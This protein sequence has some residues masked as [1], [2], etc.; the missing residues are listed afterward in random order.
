[1]AGGFQLNEVTA[2][3]TTRGSG[4]RS[5]IRPIV[6]E[7]V[8]AGVVPRRG[9][10]AL[11]SKVGDFRA[12]GNGRIIPRNKCLSRGIILGNYFLSQSSMPPMF[13]TWV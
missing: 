13:V 5:A 4:E 3:L 11:C 10:R 12:L 1:M 7:G 2:T 6:R 8:I 9:C